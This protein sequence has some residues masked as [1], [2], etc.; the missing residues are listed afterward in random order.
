M[1]SIYF[2]FEF[3]KPKDSLLYVFHILGRLKWGDRIC[4][5]LLFRAFNRQRFGCNLLVS[6]CWSDVAGISI[7]KVTTLNT[8]THTYTYIHIHIH[9]SIS[10][11]FNEIV[12]LYKSKLSSFS[13][14]TFGLVIF[15][16]SYKAFRCLFRRLALS[17]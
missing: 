16:Q 10:S 6:S 9:D 13:L 5:A 8:N 2:F 15:W 3:F 12:F 17:G 1:L 4:H 11:T 14:V 7:T